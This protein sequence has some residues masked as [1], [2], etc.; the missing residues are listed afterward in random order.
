MRRTTLK[1]LVVI[2]LAIGCLGAATAGAETCANTCV[3][4]AIPSSDGIQTK[5]DGTADAALW[6]PSQELR[7]VQI[8]ALNN[9]G[10]SCDVTISDVR[11]DE[12]T[13]V[14]GSGAPIEDAVDCHN[15]G[16]A[17]SVELRSARAENGDGRSYQISFAMKDPACTATAKT[18]EVLVV[19]PRD[20]T[21]TTSLKPA[22]EQSEITTASYAGATL[23]CSPDR[24]DRVASN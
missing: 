24:F 12:A 9:R 8:S 6:P 4:M 13:R 10:T 21:L 17:S 2:T 18:D 1:H 3:T 22:A 7:K 16:D 23:K 5:L 20:Q 19:V 11:Q 15:E 14:A